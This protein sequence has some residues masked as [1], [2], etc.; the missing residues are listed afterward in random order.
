V[1]HAVG[2]ISSEVT[3]I[4]TSFEQCV[5]WARE[6]TGINIRGYA[7]DIQ[8]TQSDPRVGGIALDRFFGHASVVVGIGDN[9]IIV[10]EANWIHG[11]ITERKVSKAAIRGYVY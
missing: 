11:K 1:Q 2:S 7:G 4:G 9:Y 10:H 8:S 6:Q 5:P 3:I